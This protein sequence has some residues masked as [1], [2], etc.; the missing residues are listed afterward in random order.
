MPHSSRLGGLHV[1]V[2]STSLDNRLVW[3][4]T[5]NINAAANLFA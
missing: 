2:R 4:G 3:S 5:L 1:T